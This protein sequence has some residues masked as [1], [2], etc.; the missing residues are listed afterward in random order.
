M[1]AT[2]HTLPMAPLITDR[3][4]NERLLGRRVA[5]R[6]YGAVGRLS[7]DYRYDRGVFWLEAETNDDG[8]FWW[9]VNSIEFLGPIP[10]APCP[11]GI[12]A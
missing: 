8:R 12:R 2:I 4:Y 10:L 6:Y 5:H 9:A 1:S 7:G 11:G 3:G